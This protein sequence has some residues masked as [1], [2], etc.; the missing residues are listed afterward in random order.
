MTTRSRPRFWEW[1]VSLLI[2]LGLGVLALGIYHRAGRPDPLAAARLAYE[3]GDWPRAASLA[4]ERLQSGKED[5]AALRLLARSS[6]RMGRDAAGA[7]LYRERLPDAANDSEDAFLIG[8]SAGRMGDEARRW[9]SGRRRQKPATIRKPSWRWPTCSRAC[10]ASMSPPGSPSVWRA[11]PAGRPRASCCWAPTAS[12]SRTTPAQA[13]RSSAVSSSIRKLPGRLW[14]RPSIASCWRAACS[15]WAGRTRPITGLNLFLSL[16]R[17]SLS[18]LKP[19]GSRA[20]R[21]SSKNSPIGSGPSWAGPESIAPRT[22]SSPSR[23]STRDRTDARAAMPTSR[24][25][26]RPRGTHARFTAARHCSRCRG[27][28]SRCPIPTIPPCGTPSPWNGTGSSSRALSNPSS[29]SWC[30]RTRSA[31]RTGT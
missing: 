21:R 18:I 22:R 29:T 27:R 6:I 2:L 28:K 8:L 9:P 17:A 7:T 15:T 20:A 11:F 13:R 30:S 19:P 24:G 31:P 23:P 1:I 3:R 10:S 5:P 14:N 25:H 26:T 12:R 16:R 4:R